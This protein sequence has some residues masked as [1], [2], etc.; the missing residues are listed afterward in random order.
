MKQSSILLLEDDDADAMLI[1]RALERGGVVA[2]ISVAQSR[3]DYLQALNQPHVDLVI[4]DS[5]IPSL[6]PLDALSLIGE[7]HPHASFI[8]LSGAINHRTAQRIREA[9][10]IA[11]LEKG[12]LSKLIPVVQHTL[13]H[14]SL[15]QHSPAELASSGQRLITE[16]HAAQRLVQA[17][18]DL[19]AARDVPTIQGI[20]RRA[21]RELNGADGATFVLRDNGQCYYADED[22]IAP[23]WKGQR[24][25][26]SACISGWAMLNKQAAVVAD[27]EQDARIP[28]DAYRPTFVRSLVMVPI[29]SEAPI[30]AIGN[31]WATHHVPTQAEV[32]VIQALADATSIALEN[33]R[34]YQE[35]EMRVASRTAE[36][37]D[38]NQ[39]L[40]EFSYF[41]SHDLRAP[42]RHI[43]AFGDI[44]REETE[45]T[46]TAEAGNALDRIDAAANSMGDLLE[47]LLTLAHSGQQPMCVSEVNMNALVD[48]AVELVRDTAAR[49]VDFKMGVLPPAGGDK[50]L[51]SQVWSN[52]IGNAVKY[53][54]DNPQPVV[55]IGS[56][57]DAN[58]QPVYF[59]RDNGVGFAMHDATQLFGAFK[60]LESGRKFSGSGVGLAIVHRIITRHGGRIWAESRP[61]QG[62]TFFF[63]IAARTRAQ[64]H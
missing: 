56:S 26:M 19:S 16:K 53:S 28:L 46:L 59:V 21:A 60:R 39:A 51:L 7:H 13:E 2:D 8:V 49:P 12:D 5:S 33:V 55:E 15:P 37:T 34:V 4:S 17:V 40:E 43:R 30:G 47:G 57:A 41:V 3:Q 6:S 50:V 35:L 27:I 64:M 24:F 18:K 52:L 25:P 31:Y 48:S 44:L 54:G 63:T 58:G 62:A 32:G 1:R 11:C 36:L 23:L 22:A 61:G 45:G 29:R 10:A 9:G 42:L 38:L 20:V 14:K